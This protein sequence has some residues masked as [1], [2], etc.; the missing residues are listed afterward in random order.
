[1]NISQSQSEPSFQWGALAILIAGLLVVGA[2]WVLPVYLKSVNPVLLKEAGK[3]TP[4]LSEFGRSLAELERIGSAQ[5]VWE[6]SK[7]VVDSGEPLLAAAVADLS[8]RH[9]EMVAW[10]GREPFLDTLIKRQNTSAKPQSQP[11]LTL[12]LPEHARSGLREYL[13]SSRS[14]AVLSLLQTRHLNGYTRFIRADRPGGQPLDATAILA[15]LLYHGNRFSPSLAKEVKELADHANQSGQVEVL[16]EFYLD[17][18]T[19]GKRLNLLQL[20]DLLALSSDTKAVAQFSYVAKVAPERFPLIYA[21]AL[22]TSKTPDGVTRYVERHDAKGLA[23]LAF[24]AQ[25]GQGA[26]KELVES[27]LPVNSSL[28]FATGELVAFAFRFP[29]LTLALKYF[30]FLLGGLLAFC[31]LD[32]FLRDPGA[33]LAGGPAAL[34]QLRTGL[35]A[36]LLCFVLIGLSEP[37]LLKGNAASRPAV[38]VSIPALASG[39]EILPNAPTRVKPTMDLSTIVSIAVF[40]L[41]QVLVYV[42]CLLKISEIDRQQVP[43]LLKLRLMENEENLFDSGLYVGIAGTAAALV[44]QVLGVIE[45]NLLAAYSSNL[46]GI[47]CVALVKIRSVRP[48]KR[49][50]ILAMENVGRPAEYPLPIF[51]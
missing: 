14:P 25:C 3:N 16:E 44:L 24:A 17:L 31:G 13:E 10:G 27:Q 9:P 37:F 35:V 40:A 45:P 11:V 26:V 15:G 42:T 50:L 19:L 6:A 18:L 51:K 20:S 33:R 46:F 4:S 36:V 43:P 38:T 22:M 39:D 30:S 32:R 5:L 29:R 7:L 49:K 1:M 12:F 21:A 2:G 34:P 23:D 8:S 48:Y 47:T 41:I 28:S